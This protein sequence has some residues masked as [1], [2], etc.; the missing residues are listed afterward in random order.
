MILA[1]SIT[2]L[3]KNSLDIFEFGCKKL[4]ITD[5]EKDR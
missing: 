5:K 4:I 3:L 2:D 1:N